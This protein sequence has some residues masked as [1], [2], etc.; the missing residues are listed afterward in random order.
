MSKKLLLFTKQTFTTGTYHATLQTFLKYKRK[1]GVSEYTIQRGFFN[2]HPIG[3]ELGNPSIS[4]LNQDWLKQYVDRLWARYARDTVRTAVG[5]IRDFFRWCKKKGH[6]KKNL[7]KHIKPVSRKP[8][9]IQKPKAAREDVCL[10]TLAYLSKG[11]AGYV[12][13]DVFGVLALSEGMQWPDSKKLLLRDLFALTFLYETGARVGEVSK[14]G[15]VV[16]NKATAI[17]QPVYYVTVS[18]KYGRPDRYF[19]EKTAEIWRLWNVIKPN[20]IYAVPSWRVGG[21]D[22]MPPHSISCMCVRHSKKFGDP[23]RA[24]ALRHAK[25][26]RTRKIA[27]LEIASL[28]VDHSD[29]NTTW[30]YANFEDNELAEAATASGLL[31]DIWSSSQ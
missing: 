19:T 18:G 6:L 22:L 31:I 4:E 29:L 28:L 10:K 27:G 8:H 24:N 26:K 3:E 20:S 9:A 21:A 7:A 30:G 13:R 12:Y 25:I 17:R 2:L 5:D 15:T 11:L 16:M 1:K 23:F 14:L